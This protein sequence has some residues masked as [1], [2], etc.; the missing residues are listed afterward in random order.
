MI[1]AVSSTLQKDYPWL[2]TDSD[3]AYRFEYSTAWR[4]YSWRAKLVSVAPEYNIDLNSKEHSVPYYL[5]Y[6]SMSTNERTFFTF[7][8]DGLTSKV[9]QPKKSLS[10]YCEWCFAKTYNSLLSYYYCACCIIYDL[11]LID[12]AS[13]VYVLSDTNCLSI[14]YLNVVSLRLLLGVYGLIL[15]NEAIS[16]P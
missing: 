15:Q 1:N 3:M 13:R 10:T 8:R 12:M 6:V 11:H 9:V 14:S 7:S 2:D 16:V 5:N 4:F